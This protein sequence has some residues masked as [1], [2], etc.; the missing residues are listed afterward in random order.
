MLS[1][2]CPCGLTATYITNYVKALKANL[3]GEG[4]WGTWKQWK[5]NGKKQMRCIRIAN[6]LKAMKDEWEEQK[7]ID[8]FFFFKLIFFSIAFNYY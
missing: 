3:L 6:H 2:Y 8:F 1:R 4:G 7:T 5:M